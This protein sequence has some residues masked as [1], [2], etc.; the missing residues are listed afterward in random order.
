MKYKKTKIL[1]GIEFDH[2][3]VYD[4]KYIKTR[5]KRFEDK[6]IT[7]FTKDEIPREN[8]HYSCIAAIYIDSAINL[9]KE[10][11]P[12]INPEEC[13]FRLKKEKHWLF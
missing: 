7:K 5:L 11:Y 6:V 3:P 2:Q 9:K 12:Q 13:K 1:V 8:S 4:E 10:Y